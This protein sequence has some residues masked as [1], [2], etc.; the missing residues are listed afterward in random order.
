M[1]LPSL[2][3]T[4]RKPVLLKMI[5]SPAF[6]DEASVPSRT[7][8]SLRS[9]P[10]PTASVLFNRT[11][12]PTSAKYPPSG[13]PEGSVNPRTLDTTKSEVEMPVGKSS[14]LI[15]ALLFSS[16]SQ[17]SLSP[18]FALLALVPSRSKASSVIKGCRV[19]VPDSN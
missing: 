6:V 16:C 4:S 11:L 7:R 1:M 2:A 13:C 12:L 10:P 18:A 3:A 17:R 8:P 14:P 19:L 5:L 15:P 9:V